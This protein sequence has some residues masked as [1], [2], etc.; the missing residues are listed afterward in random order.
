MAG[1]LPIPAADGPA[2]PPGVDPMMAMMMSGMSEDSLW[3]KA[4]ALVPTAD[5]IL[6]AF[7]K[8][9]KNPMWGNRGKPAFVAV[10][11]KEI[12]DRLQEILG[13]AGVTAGYYP[14][15]SNEELMSIPGADV[16]GGV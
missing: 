1:P 14:P 7:R 10:D 15:P 11:A 16:G 12:V 5:D 13:P 4:S 2:V 8:A 6:Q 3:H 9:L